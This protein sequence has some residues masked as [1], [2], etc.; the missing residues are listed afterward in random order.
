MI[1][2]YFLIEISL[3]ILVLLCVAGIIGT[4]GSCQDELQREEA[5]NPVKAAK[6]RCYSKFSGSRPSCWSEGDW[7]VFCER[8][9]CKESK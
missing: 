2:K 5:K 1:K 6:S 3:S 7:I 4:F 9:Q 8:I